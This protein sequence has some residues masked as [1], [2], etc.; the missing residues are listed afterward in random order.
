[1]TKKYE[2]LDEYL[3]DLDAIKEQIGK[4]TEGMNAKQLRAYFA[5]GVRELE[6]A[7]GI[8]LRLRRPRRTTSPR[9][10]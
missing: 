1:M 7:T 5:R 4:E 10:R 6:R 3:D 8:K 9:K 2:T